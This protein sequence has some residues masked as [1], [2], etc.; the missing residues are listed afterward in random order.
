[1]VIG[2]LDQDEAQS[3]GILDPRL[4]ET[5]RLLLRFA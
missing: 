3:V 5:P 2:D 1:M 4:D